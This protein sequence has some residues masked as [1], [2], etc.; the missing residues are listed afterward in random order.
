M[1]NKELRAK[2]SKAIAEEFEKDE[3]TFALDAELKPTLDLDSLS[4]VDLVVLV[5]ETAGVTLGDE[6]IKHVKTFRDLYEFVET[7][8]TK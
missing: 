5:E 2:I 7:H 3:E 1:E 6:D 4:L 8:T